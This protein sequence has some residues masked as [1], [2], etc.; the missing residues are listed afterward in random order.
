MA[1]LLLPSVSAPPN[2]CRVRP[3][4]LISFLPSVS[5]PPNNSR[6]RPCGLSL[7]KISIAAMGN[8]LPSVQERDV[9]GLLVRPAVCIL[10]LH[11]P[12]IDTLLA[13]L[14]LVVAVPRLVDVK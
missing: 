1:S 10:A 5:A 4:G 2:K 11:E 14:A 7:H 8:A 12:Y 13:K 6:D 9:T 3:H